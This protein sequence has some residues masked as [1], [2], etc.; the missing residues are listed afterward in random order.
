MHFPWAIIY[1][2]L[3]HRTW[4]FDN[5]QEVTARSPSVG[6]MCAS[7]DGVGHTAESGGGAAELEL[8]DVITHVKLGLGDVVAGKG[9]ILC[10]TVEYTTRVLKSMKHEVSLIRSYTTLELSDVMTRET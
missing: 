8:S 1:S 10:Q 7:D 2:C 4:R 6:G 3:C 9:D 5:G